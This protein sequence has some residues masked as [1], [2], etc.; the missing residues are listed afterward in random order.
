MIYRSHIHFKY[1]ARGGGYESLLLNREEQR[2][3]I[4][5]FFLENL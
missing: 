5:E 1:D 4:E 3:E 2:K